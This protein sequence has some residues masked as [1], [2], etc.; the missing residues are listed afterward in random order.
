MKFA[1]A[2]VAASL[3]AVRFASAAVVR[4]VPALLARQGTDE[5]NHPDSTNCLEAIKYEG[6]RP[7]FQESG[8]TLLLVS[9]PI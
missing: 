8:T 5:V 6:Y 4:P 9:R 3:A 1:I 2:F 7:D